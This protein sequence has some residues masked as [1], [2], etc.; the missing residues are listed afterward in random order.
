MLPQVVHAVLSSA[1]APGVGSDAVEA[2]ELLVRVIDG[3]ERAWSEVVDRFAGLVWS[4]ARSY[5]LS[6]RATDDVW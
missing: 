3:D 5:R 6:S 2:Q 1:P 4:I